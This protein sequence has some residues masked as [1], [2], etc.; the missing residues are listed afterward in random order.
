MPESDCSAGSSGRNEHYDRTHLF[1]ELRSVEYSAEHKHNIVEKIIS[2]LRSVNAVNVLDVG[3]GPG[4]YA[5][6]L[7]SVLGCNV[8][9]LDFSGFHSLYRDF[10]FFGKYLTPLIPLRK[11]HIF[12]SFVWVLIQC[13]CRRDDS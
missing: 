11:P 12:L 5:V 1:W 6:K 7:A 10:V 4:H 8:T 2:V 13:G 9:C 3:S